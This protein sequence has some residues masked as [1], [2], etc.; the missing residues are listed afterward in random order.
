[1]SLSDRLVM[2]PEMAGAL[3]RSEDWVRR[4]WLRLHQEHGMPRKCSVGWQWPRK[5]MEA[6]LDAGG[7]TT[8]QE[9]ETEDQPP[10]TSGGSSHLRLVANQNRDLAARYSG[11]VHA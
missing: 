6:W 7:I 9:D 2:L 4:H 11:R 10:P 3:Q 1:M 8:T 5:A